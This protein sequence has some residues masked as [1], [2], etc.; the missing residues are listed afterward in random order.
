MDKEIVRAYLKIKIQRAALVKQ[1]SLLEKEEKRLADLILPHVPKIGQIVECGATFRIKSKVKAMVGD[2]GLFYEYI[3]A[4]NAF[5]LLHR[6]VTE[7]AVKLRWDDRV[8]IPGVEAV[9]D[10]SLEVE[11]NAE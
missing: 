2:W 8:V 4:N 3:R 7:T 1:A 9:T 11:L 5:D 10:E 6:R